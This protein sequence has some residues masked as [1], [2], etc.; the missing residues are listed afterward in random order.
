MG[1]SRACASK[2][3][4][5]YRRYGEVGPLDRPPIPHVQPTAAS[6]AVVAQIEQMRR[7]D[8]WS[9]PRI[10]HELEDRPASQ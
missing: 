10:A 7:S 6:G 5:R 8:K 9:A 3:V 2:W 4:N 1:I